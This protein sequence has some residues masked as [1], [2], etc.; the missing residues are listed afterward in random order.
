MATAI[1][2]GQLREVLNG[3]SILASRRCVARAGLT[4]GVEVECQGTVLG[5]WHWR[6]GVF[7]LVGPDAP[8]EAVALET[9]AEA[10]YYTRETLCP[11]PC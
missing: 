10:L 3:D 11:G 7:E 1:M 6:N 8:G 4:S 2:E 5:I 9:V